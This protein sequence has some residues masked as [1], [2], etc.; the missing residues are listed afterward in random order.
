MGRAACADISDIHGVRGGEVFGLLQKSPYVWPRFVSRDFFFFFPPFF[1]PTVGTAI[2][3]V[4]A[5]HDD[6]TQRSSYIPVNKRSVVDTVRE[7]SAKK[8]KVDVAEPENDP[9]ALLPKPAFTLV[10]RARVAT[11]LTWTATSPIGAGL[12]NLGNT[13]YLNSVLQCLVYAPPLA[14]FVLSKEHLERC[15]RLKVKRGEKVDFWFFVSY[16]V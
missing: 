2:E 10:P 12:R 4:R 1:Q 3:F 11:M 13:C 5:V 15:K 6:Q 8:V 9:S 7:T 16:T 14:N